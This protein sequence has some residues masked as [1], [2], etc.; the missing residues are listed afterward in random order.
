MNN[1][2]KYIYRALN[3]IAVLVLMTIFALVIAMYGVVNGMI[4][5]LS[6]FQKKVFGRSTV[7][8]YQKRNSLLSKL[9]VSEDD[10]HEGINKSS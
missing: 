3:L 7:N 6:T 9:T 1:K 10:C 2:K 4:M 5:V 8:D